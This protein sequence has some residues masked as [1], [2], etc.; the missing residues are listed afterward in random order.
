MPYSLTSVIKN[1]S[2]LDIWDAA[3]DQYKIS[4]YFYG[5]DQFKLEMAASTILVGRKF[6]FK[7]VNDD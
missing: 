2:P 5:I 4:G 1:D 7:Q 3:Y 6:Q